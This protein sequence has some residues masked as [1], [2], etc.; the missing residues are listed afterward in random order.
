MPRIYYANVSSY[1]DILTELFARFLRA[2]GAS[3]KT[4]K[5]YVHDLNHFLG[6]VD[7]K[8][9]SQESVEAFV[10][11]IHA[12]TIESYKNA[13]R[14]EKIPAATLNRRL[15]SLRMFFRACI[16]SGFIKA[17]PTQDI[18]NVSQDKSV[19]L[20]LENFCTDLQ[21]DGA[22]KSTIRNYLADIK[23][24]LTWIEQTDRTLDL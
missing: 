15:S 17:N 1:Q 10:Q 19:V 3:T 8:T 2:N 20:I 18:A 22:S 4:I 12:S 11:S 6:W 13:Q 24:F 7:D 14:V 16:D 23:H 21:R 9:T 5:N